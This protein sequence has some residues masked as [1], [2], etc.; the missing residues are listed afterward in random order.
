MLLNTLRTFLL[1]TLFSCASP[2]EAVLT[3]LEQLKTNLAAVTEIRF[4]G[5]IGTGFV[6]NITEKD[7]VFYHDLLTAA[8]L[9][10]NEGTVYPTNASNSDPSYT[11]AEVVFKIENQRIIT[12]GT[13]VKVNREDDLAVIRVGVDRELCLPFAIRQNDLYLNYLNEVGAHLTK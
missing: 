9:V 12:T 4:K 7:G 8:H 11:D 10:R 13:I 1:L 5:A 3:E 6:F 2:K